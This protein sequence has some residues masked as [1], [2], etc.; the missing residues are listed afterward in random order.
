MELYASA[1]KFIV[2]SCTLTGNEIGEDKFYVSFAVNFRYTFKLWHYLSHI[3]WPLEIDYF[4]KSA[5][6][7]VPEMIEN[8]PHFG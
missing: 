7:I 1:T 3:C 5:D 8:I 6:V 2:S 4:K